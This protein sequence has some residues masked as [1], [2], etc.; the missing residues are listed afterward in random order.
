MDNKPGYS[1]VYMKANNLLTKEALQNHFSKR[2]AI[3][4]TVNTNGIMNSL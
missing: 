1:G 2:L 4:N 3:L